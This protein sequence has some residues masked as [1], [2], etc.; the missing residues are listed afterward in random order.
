MSFLTSLS[1]TLLCVSFEEFFII[2]RNNGKIL[3]IFALVV[4]IYR[5]KGFACVSMWIWRIRRL[6]L[7]LK[8]LGLDA[9]NL[10]KKIHRKFKH[11]LISL[12][13]FLTTSLQKY[14]PRVFMIHVR[15]IYSNIW[16]SFLS[17]KSCHFLELV[18][19]DYLPLFHLL[20]INV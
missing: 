12:I 20:K 9:L 10:M 19:W 3:F 11:A 5:R 2:L 13:Y 8:Y 6:D 7:I 17:Q 1:E 18:N 15:F 4:K 14:F 16:L